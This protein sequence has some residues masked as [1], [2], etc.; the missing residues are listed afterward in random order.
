MVAEVEV[1]L[2]LLVHVQAHHILHLDQLVQ[3]EE[4]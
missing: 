3:V 1:E 2:V 4:Q